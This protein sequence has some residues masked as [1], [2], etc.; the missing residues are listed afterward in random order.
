MV[1]HPEHKLNIPALVFCMSWCADFEFRVTQDSSD[2]YAMLFG[3]DKFDEM[4][5]EL[6]LA[7]QDMMDAM[8]G[9][10]GDEGMGS[11]AK[12][13]KD[14]QVRGRPPARPPA[15]RPFQVHA[16]ISTGAERQRAVT[17]SCGHSVQVRR[18]AKCALA[19]LEKLAVLT[20]ETTDSESGELRQPMNEFAFLAKEKAN[21]EEL[22]EQPFGAMLVHAIGHM[23]VT[24]GEIWIGLHSGFLGA[25]G[26]I[27]QMQQKKHVMSTYLST[28]GAAISAFKAAR[29]M[30]TDGP[31]ADCPPLELVAAM[32]DDAI[33]MFLEERG[34]DPSGTREELLTRMTLPE[35]A[36]PQHHRR[37]PLSACTA[38]APV[39]ETTARRR[40]Q[41]QRAPTTR[42]RSRPAWPA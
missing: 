33:R 42:R 32:D 41:P 15:R 39:A 2:M 23:Y 1:R 16:G 21:A 7:N 5:G 20:E 17:A 34:R 25:S 38:A 4:I 19:L 13:M 6:M 22:C 37:T 28:A 8:D 12:S 40:H 9:Y 30:D 26:H 3:S 14:K 24:A 18:K 31:I 10:G 35:G 36:P 27:K 29:K 11:A